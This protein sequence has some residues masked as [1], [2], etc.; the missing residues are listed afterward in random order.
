[1]ILL[2]IS[3]LSFSLLGNS[4]KAQFSC[5][6][7]NLG[8]DKREVTDSQETRRGQN[9]VIGTN[10]N[11]ANFYQYLDAE[12]QR[13]LEKY[14]LWQESIE[15]QNQERE[16]SSRRRQENWELLKCSALGADHRFC[17]ISE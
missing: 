12:G 7:Q 6:D 5:N 14:R 1:L 16:E 10:C 3:T 9:V 17:T 15:R 4:A 8:T 13:D 2:G 11:N